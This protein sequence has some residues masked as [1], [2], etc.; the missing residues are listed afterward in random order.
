MTKQEILK[1]VREHFKGGGICDDGSCTEYYGDP[2]AFVK[3]AE[4]IYHKGHCA[5]FCKGHD[6]GWDY[7]GEFCD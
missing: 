7:R 1:L 3:F 4:K 5:G 2:D 6:A